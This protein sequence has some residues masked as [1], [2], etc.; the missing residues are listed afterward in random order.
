MAV[1]VPFRF[2]QLGFTG[3]LPPF[4]LQQ[5]RDQLRYRPGQFYPV[6]RLIIGPAVISG[7]PDRHDDQQQYEQQA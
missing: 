4:S 6:G 3:G 5:I 1:A 2:R 7:K